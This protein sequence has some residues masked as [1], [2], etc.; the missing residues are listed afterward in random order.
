MTIRIPGIVVCLSGL[1]FACESHADMKITFDGMYLH[2]QVTRSYVLGDAWDSP[3]REG[4][5]GTM[6]GI[7]SFNDGDL[8]TLCMEL[9]QSASHS[10]AF[11]EA[12]SFAEF[13]SHIFDRSLV[14]MSLFDKYW[15]HVLESDSHSM[16]S[17]FAMMTW[18]VMLEGFSTPGSLFDQISIGKGAVQFSDV[19]IEAMAYYQEMSEQLYIADSSGG[20]VAYTH[21]LLQDQVGV[22]P[23]PSILAVFALAGLRQRRRRC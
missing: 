2:E 9:K 22:I 14:L 16:A 1:V 18:E 12:N 10:A 7:L 5:A 20:L 17:A 19:S 3:H 6:S 13:D 23:S 21:P 8:L 4:G 15:D 11:Y